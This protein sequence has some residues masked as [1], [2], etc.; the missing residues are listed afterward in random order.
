MLKL[1]TSRHFCLSLVPFLPLFSPSYPSRTQM[2]LPPWL[3]P[4]VLGSTWAEAVRFT[5]FWR[6]ASWWNPSAWNVLD[7]QWMFEWVEWEGVRGEVL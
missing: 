4:I 5:G 2:D 1:N 7:A 6:A 3:P